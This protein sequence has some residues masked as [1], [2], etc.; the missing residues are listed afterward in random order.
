MTLLAYAFPNEIFLPKL[1][2]ASWKSPAN[3]NANTSQLLGDAYI[4][5]LINYDIVV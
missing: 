2:V 5:W 1:S 4:L 3:N